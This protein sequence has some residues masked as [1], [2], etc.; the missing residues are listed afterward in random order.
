MT[1]H[2]VPQQASGNRNLIIVGS[3]IAVLV[4]AMGG[5]VACGALVGL[6]AMSDPG[7]GS[8]SGYG[9]ILGGGLASTEWKGDLTCDDGSSTPVVYKFSSNGYPLYAYTTASGSKQEEL[10]SAG[11]TIKFAPAGGGVSVLVVEAISVSSDQV[12]LTTSFS[13]Q[14]AAGGTMIQ[15]RSRTSEEITLAASVLD[16]VM[17]STSDSAASQPGYVTSGEDVTTCRGKLSKQ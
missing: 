7:G 6:S 17:N 8:G 12:A 3:I 13:H 11:Q 10:R 2:I 5:C 14:R 15:S 16:V 4:L 1:D 9:S